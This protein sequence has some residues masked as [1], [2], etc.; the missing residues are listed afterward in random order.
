[1]FSALTIFHRKCVNKKEFPPGV[2]SLRFIIVY[3]YCERSSSLQWALLLF[4]LTIGGR[5]NY[6]PPVRP[7]SLS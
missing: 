2:G 7:E 5:G 1:M 3:I 4:W 6:D